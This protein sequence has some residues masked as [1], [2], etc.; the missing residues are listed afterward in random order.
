[1]VN[2]QWTVMRC[3]A[4]LTCKVQ[5]WIVWIVDGYAGRIPSE[6]Q[7]LVVDRGVAYV[8]AH[9]NL[10]IHSHYWKSESKNETN[11]D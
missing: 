10:Q 4:V 5:R 7:Q 1:M 2:N 3:D 11:F 8:Y 6:E 9:K